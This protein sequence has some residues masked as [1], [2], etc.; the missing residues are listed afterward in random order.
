MYLT[1]I[2]VFCWAGHELFGVVGDLE[3]GLQRVLSGHRSRRHLE[4]D[5]ERELN[6]LVGRASVFGTLLIL[7]V[8]RHG[9]RHQHQV[10]NARVVCVTGL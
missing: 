5:V 3:L 2:R 6:R 4:V 8:L 1:D 7:G 10:E 9:A